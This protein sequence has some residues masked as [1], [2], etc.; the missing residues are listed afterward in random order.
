MKLVVT[1]FLLSLQEICFQLFCHMVY[2]YLNAEITKVTVVGSKL[3]VV[4]HI[5]VQIA[6]AAV[7][8]AA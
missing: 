8:V 1:A 5:K 4:S 2:F 6:T 7:S 3:E